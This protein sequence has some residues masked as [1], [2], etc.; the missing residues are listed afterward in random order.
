MVASELDQWRAERRAKREARRAKQRE[1]NVVRAAKM[2]A[3]RASMLHSDQ[4]LNLLYVTCREPSPIALTDSR[5]SVASRL[6]S[7]NGAHA[8]SGRSHRLSG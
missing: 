6:G 8:G 1:Q 5:H 2:H 7:L 4:S 3:A